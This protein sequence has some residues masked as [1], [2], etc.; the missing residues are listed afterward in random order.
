[1]K[2][3][4]IFGPFFLVLAAAAGARL[5]DV[6]DDLAAQRQSIQT[7]WTRVAAALQARADLLPGLADT[8]QRLTGSP[9]DASAATAAAR[10]DLAR[11]RTPEQKIEANGR[12]SA[13][14]S[15]L[16]LM[17]ENHPHLRASRE[18]Q[19]IGDDVAAAD[20]RIAIERRKY[21]EILEHYNAQ[22]QRF[23]DNVVA[24]LSG[25]T[26]NDAYFRTDGSTRAAPKERF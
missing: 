16:L 10:A 20:N 11:G 24:S 5:V 1:M 15:R 12:L 7:Q 22:I 23:P 14:L 17:A 21:N 6:R 19:R 8:V 26:R 25:F 13:V 3:L 4:L 18:F 2:K 9:A